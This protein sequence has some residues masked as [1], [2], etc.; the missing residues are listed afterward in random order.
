MK[1]VWIPELGGPGFKS[2]LCYI[3]ATGQDFGQSIWES[4]LEQTMR[5]LVIITRLDLQ[6]CPEDSMGYSGTQDVQVSDVSLIKCH[7]P[8]LCQPG[9]R[10]PGSHPAWKPVADPESQR[11]PPLEKLSPSP[12]PATCSAVP[13]SREGW[14]RHFKNSLIIL[15]LPGY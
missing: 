4:F 12:M 2:W 9:P 8:N 11:W 7:G 15:R 6:G 3:L 14:Y 10:W 1:S 13:I 5:I